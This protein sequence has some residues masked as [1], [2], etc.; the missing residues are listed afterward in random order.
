MLPEATFV[1]YVIIKITQGKV[2]G[3]L[4]LFHTLPTNKPAITV[5]ALLHQ[6]AGHPCSKAQTYLKI[7]PKEERRLCSEK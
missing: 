5:V 2:Y 6:N 1:S 7:Y 4:L 3:L